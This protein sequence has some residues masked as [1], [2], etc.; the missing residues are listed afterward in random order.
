MKDKR[1]PRKLK[2]RLKKLHSKQWKII[3]LWRK[4]IRPMYG[5]SLLKEMNNTY[6]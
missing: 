4:N 6:K 2:K 1:I 5:Y 3:P